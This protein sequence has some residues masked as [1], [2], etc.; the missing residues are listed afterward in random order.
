MEYRESTPLNLKPNGGISRECLADCFAGALMRLPDNGTERRLAASHKHNEGYQTAEHTSVVH[1][2]TS[3]LYFPEG[4]A[5]VQ[6][7]FGGLAI[8]IRA[9]AAALRTA[10]TTNAPP[11]AP[12][13]ARIWAPRIGPKT[14]AAPHAEKTH[15]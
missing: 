5:P 14:P 3:L 13:A 10:S 4:R 7:Y 2:L 6:I 12:V 11:Q 9:A 8:N 15:P 1:G